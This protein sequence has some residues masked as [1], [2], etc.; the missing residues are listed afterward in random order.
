MRDVLPPPVDLLAPLAPMST[1]TTV[2]VATPVT[3]APTSSTGPTWTA[4]PPTATATASYEVSVRVPAALHPMAPWRI[5]GALALTTTFA[6]MGWQVKRLVDDQSW[7]SPMMWMSVAAGVIAALCVLVWTWIATDNAKRLVEP[8]KRSQL[9]DPNA[10]V[11][12][13]IGPFVLV[14]V[15]VGIVAV[16]GARTALDNGNDA[17]VSTLPVAVAVIALLLAVPMTYRPLN[18][19]AAVVRQVG[20]YSVRLAQWMWVPIVMGVVGVG[21]IVALRFAVVDDTGATSSSADVLGSAPLWV[22]AVAAI[23]PCVVVVLLAWRAASSVEDAFRVASA[24]RGHAM[25]GEAPAVAGS[26]VQRR[27]ITPDRIDRIDLFPGAELLRLVTVTLLAGAA[28]LS[29]VG[30]GVTALLW[31]DSR[32]TG[33]LP[34]ERQ[35]VW[36]TLD[37]LGAA[38]SLVTITLVA[39][40][41]MWTFVTV[42][43]V[44]MT[45]GRRRNPVLAALAWPAS[46]A[47]VWWIADRVIVD[48]S[49]GRVVLGF[50]AQAGV[51][52]V[53]FLLLERSADAVGARRTPLRIVY[54]LAVVLVVHVQG[55]G[56]LARLPDSVSTT[57]VGRLAGYLA[58]GA[59]IQLCSTLAVTEAC[60]SMSR[61]C[62]HEA[63]HHN[64]LVDQHVAS[65]R[66]REPVAG[67]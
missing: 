44:R 31:L 2:T 32:D 8:A 41:S 5:V 38:S 19:L 1:H 46:A 22:I 53:P 12:T 27:V 40:V 25:P 23:G 59:L 62:R 9:P 66:G 18:H 60:R 4:I 7:S 51:L 48:A 42:L 37:A 6:L 16:L 13:W 56:G 3:A 15:A 29:V 17:T 55:L 52:F 50:A 10:A 21:S 11:L 33:V 61:A 28:L 34:A 36:N 58:I 30:A 24:R 57:E 47:A 49:M 64:M 35:R 54:S 26:P 20:G 67:R 14:A 43:N 39:A 45:S 63:D 65:G